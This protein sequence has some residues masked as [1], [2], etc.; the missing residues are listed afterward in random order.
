M[1]IMLLRQKTDIPGNAYM[2]DIYWDNSKR[3]TYYVY[4]YQ[5]K[6][7]NSEI[8]YMNVFNSLEKAKAYIKEKINNNANLWAECKRTDGKYIADKKVT[9]YEVKNN[10]LY[11]IK[12]Q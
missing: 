11:Q 4:I 1:T 5:N 10:R 7:I 2:E 8:I 12:Y 6:Y 9:F 3:F